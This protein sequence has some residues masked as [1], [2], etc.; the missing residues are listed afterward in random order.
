MVLAFC[1]C[2]MALLVYFYLL[3]DGGLWARSL[4]SSLIYI[5]W[6]LTRTVSSL[7]AGLT[8]RCPSCGEGKLYSSY[9]NITESC[10]HCHKELAI[11]APGDGPAVFVIMVV[12]FAVVGAAL[13]LE[14]AY[15]PPYWLHALVWAPTIII[16]S[17]L[18]LPLFKSLF[19][20]SHFH[21]QAGEEIKR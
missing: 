8:L 11:N 16:S 19:F 3:V 12:G 2:C 15:Q 5:E 13:L 9:L 6:H 20:A 7:R 4:R 14:I 17:L 21:N 18:L 10:H 1:R